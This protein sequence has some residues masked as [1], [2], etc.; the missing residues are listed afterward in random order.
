MA[1]A[2]GCNRYLALQPFAL[3]RAWAHACSPRERD[4][5]KVQ[6]P[7][8][9]GGG[10]RGLFALFQG[11]PQGARESSGRA[12]A[13]TER[14][15]PTHA[16]GRLSLALLRL[17]IYPLQLSAEAVRGREAEAMVPQTVAIVGRLLWRLEVATSEGC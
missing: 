3:R 9:G 1:R 6:E 16:D 2:V 13:R 7:G 14:A 4:G 15:A 10:I 8:K 11:P 17:L 12:G 5:R